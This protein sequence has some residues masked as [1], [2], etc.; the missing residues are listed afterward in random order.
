M[1]KRRR[2]NIVV[3]GAGSVGSAL[4]KQF[5]ASGH[6]IVGVINR[7][8]SSSHRSA[9]ALKAEAF[10]SDFGD[11]PR[12]TNLI[13]FAAPD[14]AIP[15]LAALVA[16]RSPLKFEK[17]IAF[18]TSGVLTSAALL[19]LRLLGSTVFSLHPIQ[20]FPRRTPLARRVLSLRS[21]YYGIEGDAWAL[22]VAR[23]LVSDLGG[24]YI[25]IPAD[26]KALHHIACVFASN[27]LVVL[28]GLLED[29]SR[30]AGLNRHQYLKVFRPLIATTL[31]HIRSASPSEALTGP[32]ERGDLSTVE[33]HLEELRTSQ[34][35]LLSIYTAMGSAA[36]QLAMKKKSLS[37]SEAR[38]LLRLLYRVQ[39]TS[40]GGDSA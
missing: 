21:V 3:I 35:E 20:V 7:K 27:Y 11:L 33:R 6:R 29:A 26:R 23:K 22:R 39:G 25:V 30:E 40:S 2:L 37:K 28:M 32:I 34:P 12:S 13:F 14:S 16:S 38:Q 5:Q 10:S 8:L 31:E 24:K 19:P 15:S 9:V 36:V 4:A 17:V 1:R 18:H